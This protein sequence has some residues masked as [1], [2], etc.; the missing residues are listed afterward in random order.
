MKLIRVCSEFIRNFLRVLSK[1]RSMTTAGANNR[2]DVLLDALRSAVTFLEDLKSYPIR[3]EVK[4]PQEIAA[5]SLTRA[6][7]LLKAIVFLLENGHVFAAEPVIRAL[8]EIAFNVAWI[9]ADN[10]RAVRFRDNGLRRGQIWFETMQ[11]KYGVQFSAETTQ[12]FRN[13]FQ[14]RSQPTG[15]PFPST[16]KRAKEVVLRGK[17]FAISGMPRAYLAYRRLSGAVH[18]DFWH[19]L[20][21]AN[22]P[23]SAALWIDAGDAVAAVMFVIMAAGETLG[24]GAET[25]SIVSKLREAF[26]LSQPQQPPPPAETALPTACLSQRLAGFLPKTGHP[27]LYIASRCRQ[28]P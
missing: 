26:A 21:F 2:T 5:L 19:L 4:L 23:D 6:A 3:V 27:C 17:R 20:A 14:E 22:A 15:V 13:L 18:G 25:D 11:D 7:R 9:G 24:L 16:E 28:L 1:R 12:F 10:D 8:L